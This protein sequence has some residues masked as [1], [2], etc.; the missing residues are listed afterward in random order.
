MTRW[1]RWCISTRIIWRRIFKKEYGISISAYILQ[2][3]VEE[4]KN[5][6]V[7]SDLPINTVSIYVGYSNFFVFYKNV[8]GKHRVLPAGVPQ[9]V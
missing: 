1:R 6:L 8:Q 9:E 4:A 5:L 3:R 2:K 7:H